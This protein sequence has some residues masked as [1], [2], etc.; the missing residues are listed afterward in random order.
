VI[1][2]VDTAGG[3]TIPIRAIP[4]AGRS[5]IAG[6]RDGML[7]VRLQSAPADGAANAELVDLL[8]R[9]LRVPRRDVEI[10]SGQSSRTK[11]VRVA[12][13]TSATVLERLAPA[14]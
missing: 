8:A 7:L 4:R 5:A 9:A 2:I 10:V 13:L 6:L 12:G 14:I 3:A 11:R 1:E